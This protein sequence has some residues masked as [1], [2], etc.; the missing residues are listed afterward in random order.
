M[1]GIGILWLIAI[2]GGAFL[3]GIAFAYGISHDRRRRN[4]RSPDYDEGREPDG[5]LH[6]P[7]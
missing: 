7:H 5:S 1:E 3:L 6:R 2:A 4:V